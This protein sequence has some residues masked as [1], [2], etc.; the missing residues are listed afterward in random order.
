MHSPDIVSRLVPNQR[1]K[2]TSTPPGSCSDG[3]CSRGVAAA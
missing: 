1:L 2:P 3:W